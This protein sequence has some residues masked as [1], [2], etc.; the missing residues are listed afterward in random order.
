VLHLPPYRGDVPTSGLRVPPFDTVGSLDC[1]RISRG[2][3]EGHLAPATLRR[4]RGPA[5]RCEFE[6]DD[7]LDASDHWGHRT[8]KPAPPH[9]H[10]SVMDFTVTTNKGDVRH[11]SGASSYHLKEGGVLEV[12]DG[13]SQV[14]AVFSPSGW[15]A[16]EH[17]TRTNEA[18]L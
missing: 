4:R 2:L 7:T 11:Y 10:S 17:A 9:L 18:M 16:V 12:S 13:T 3:L 1:L 6:I 14:T 5:S 15:L 8:V